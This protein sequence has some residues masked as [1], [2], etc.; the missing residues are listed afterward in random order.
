MYDVTNAGRSASEQSTD[1]FHNGATFM[2]A[3]VGKLFLQLLGL[4]PNLSLFLRSNF[5]TFLFQILIAWLWIH[6]FVIWLNGVRIAWSRQVLNHNIFTIEIISAFFFIFWSWF[7]LKKPIT[8][9]PRAAAWID[10]FG[11]T[12]DDENSSG[13]RFLTFLQSC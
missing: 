8:Y 13:T 11:D 5:K 10:E 9:H 3:L 7:K 2:N 6:T 4:S 1:Q 12:H